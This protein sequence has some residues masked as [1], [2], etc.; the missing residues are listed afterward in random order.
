MERA[1]GGAVG[2]KPGFQGTP[3]FRSQE[4]HLVQ[5]LHGMGTSGGVPWSEDDLIKQAHRKGH[6]EHAARKYAIKLEQVPTPP[7]NPSP[8]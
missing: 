6:P 3:L 8:V 2:S 5:Q 7:C 1:L 4:V